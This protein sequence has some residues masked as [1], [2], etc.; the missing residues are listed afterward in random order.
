MCRFRTLLAHPQTTDKFIAGVGLADL[1]MRP[2]N[3]KVWATPTTDVRPDPFICRATT[4]L[5]SQMQCEWLGERVA[6]PSLKLVVSNVLNKKTAGN[7]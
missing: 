5:S 3:F 2:Y 7:W 1:F 4:D 6:A